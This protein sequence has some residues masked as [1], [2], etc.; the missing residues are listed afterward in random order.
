V[1]NDSKTLGP[2]KKLHRIL[3]A[4]GDDGSTRRINQKIYLLDTGPEIFYYKCTCTYRYICFLKLLHVEVIMEHSIFSLRELL[5]TAEIGEEE[6]TPWMQSGLVQPVGEGPDH[7]PFFDSTTLE[8]IRHI[9][10]FQEMGYGAEE[11]RKIMK[12]VGL[13]ESLRDKNHGAGKEQFLT[14]GAL[15]E[16]VGVSPRTIKHWEDKGILSPDMRSE[17]GFR[18]YRNYYVYF[19]RLIQD[20]Q[21]FGYSLDDI[22]RISDYFRAFDRIRS[23]QGAFSPADTEEQL[24]VMLEEIDRLFEKTAQLRAGINRWEELL[25]KHRRLIVNLRTKNKRRSEGIK[26]ERE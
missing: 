17:G 10:K 3:D 25:K 13:P 15:A 14:V 18:L 26:N 23:D 2:V 19:C 12:K 8:K 4:S 22:K 1:K 16:Q 24:E 11:I 5:E 20:L 7:L 6:F 21:L 9:R